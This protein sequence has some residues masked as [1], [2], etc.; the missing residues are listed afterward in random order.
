VATPSWARR[1][2]LATERAECG[3]LSIEARRS[4]I[5]FDS[6]SRRHGQ[7]QAKIQSDASLMAPGA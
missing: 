7:H 3:A 6:D 5:S 4:V 1:G 2:Q